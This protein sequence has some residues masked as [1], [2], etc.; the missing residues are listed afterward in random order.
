MTLYQAG[1]GIYDLVDDVMV[2]HK[3]LTIYYGP[4]VS[5][6]GFFEGL[7]F[8]YVD[9][10]NIAD[11]LTGVTVPAERKI[12]PGYEHNFPR[13]AAEIRKAYLAHGIHEEMR[14]RQD[15]ARSDEAAQNTQQF[16]EAVK[17]ARDPSLPKHSVYSVG[18]LRQ[19]Q[20]LAR[21]Q[22]RQILGDKL[23]L[24]FRQGN[25]V[26]QALV[27]GSLFFQVSDDSVG[28]FT[29]GGAIFFSTVYHT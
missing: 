5:A 11:M 23:L 16:I 15:Y 3:G 10:A 27:M 28:L 2:L 7:G 24:Y 17:L 22:F 13:N 1:N 14:K 20:V 8:E 19:I 26:I 12:A 4:R 21:R 6:R 18:Y 29:R 25:T 9:G